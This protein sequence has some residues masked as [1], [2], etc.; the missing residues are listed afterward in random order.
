MGPNEGNGI[1]PFKYNMMIKEHGVR[2]TA[3]TL[4]SYQIG[5][6]KTEM[7]ILNEFFLL[8]QTMKTTSRF[9]LFVSFPISNL[10]TQPFSFSISNITRFFE[11]QMKNLMLSSYFLFL[12]FF[13]N[14]KLSTIHNVHK[15][16]GV[17]ID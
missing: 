16:F 17:L 1:T 5:E 7:L 6:H 10:Q 14:L 8:K 2:W 4:K 13:Y 15:P 12:F 3:T 11:E 9:R